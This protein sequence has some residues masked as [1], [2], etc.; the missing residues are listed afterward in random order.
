MKNI[1]LII[2][3]SFFAHELIAQS[4]DECNNIEDITT[5]VKP[6]RNPDSPII[7]PGLPSKPPTIDDEHYRHIWWIHGFGGDDTAFSKAITITTDNIPHPNGGQS[8]ND[9]IGYPARQI[10]S[11]APTYG[12]GEDLHTYGGFIG[13]EI[14]KTSVFTIVQTEKEAENNFAITSSWGGNVTRMA[15][16]IKSSEENEGFRLGGI[17]SLGGSHI[18]AELADNLL[19]TLSEADAFP[20]DTFN[21]LDLSSPGEVRL[22]DAANNFLVEATESLIAG[23][24][25]DILDDDLILT[26]LARTEIGES[27][28]AAAQTFSAEFVSSLPSVLGNGLFSTTG[29]QL[30]TDNEQQLQLESFTPSTVNVAGY[31]EEDQEL[32]MWRLFYWG[33]NSPNNVP[34]SLTSSYTTD[35]QGYFEADGDEFAIE[36][37]ERNLA[38]YQMRQATSQTEASNLLKQ[39]E[40]CSNPLYFILNPYSKYLKCLE[41]S[42]RYPK[43]L[44]TIEGYQRGIEWFQNSSDFWAELTGALTYV[45][46]NSQSGTCVCSNGLSPEP[47][48]N[49]VSFPCNQSNL[50][51]IDCDAF[52][53]FI[54]NID[55]VEDR[56]ESDMVVLS[57]SAMAFPGA[58]HQFKMMG[59]N[60]FNMRNDNNTKTLLLD[61]FNGIEELGLQYFETAEK[62]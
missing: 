56:K 36:T 14:K 43:V 32:G 26:L 58:V 34:E 51:N 45:G 39:L 30:Q 47:D 42:A 54:P 11:W 7:T 2:L 60:H 10:V 55:I 49:V 50:G 3:I 19:T 53:T 20:D 12:T 52:L 28:L 46:V 24:S 61:V 59:S 38:A 62:N 29:L 4:N 16:L 8:I 37:F 31:G 15:D 48:P 18:G 21:L 23:P 5:T 40:R 6:D 41:S 33:K 57:E 17:V 27:A 35:G 22:T 1:L 9:R 44:E 13:N 25:C